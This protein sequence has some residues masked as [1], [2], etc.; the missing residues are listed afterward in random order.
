MEE[1]IGDSQLSL[2]PG[3]GCKS[4]SKSE[5]NTI[6][7][8]MFHYCRCDA[9][10]RCVIARRNKDRRLLDVSQANF[11][12]CHQVVY[13][14]NSTDNTTRECCTYDRK[15]LVLLSTT[16][17]CD[18]EDTNKRPAG[19]PLAH[20]L[21]RKRLRKTIKHQTLAPRTRPCT[22]G[23]SMTRSIEKISSAPYTCSSRPMDLS[24]TW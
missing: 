11:L 7:Y 15:T 1:T 22:S 2:G 13:I 8:T 16:A 10:G 23:I 21:L 18:R 19:W 17:R 14:F 9:R 12:C 4:K 6:F 3:E 24:S 5:Y 20:H